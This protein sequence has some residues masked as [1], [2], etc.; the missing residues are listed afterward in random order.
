MIDPLWFGVPAAIA[1]AVLALWWWR[2]VR[3]RAL[4]RQRLGAELV[5]AGEARTHNHNACHRGRHVLA[6]SGRPTRQD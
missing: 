1:L 2:T 5:A 3:P 4:A 6:G